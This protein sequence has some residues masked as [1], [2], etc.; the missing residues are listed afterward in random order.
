MQSN[1]FFKLKLQSKVS[2]IAILSSVWEMQRLDKDSYSEKKLTAY[3]KNSKKLLSKLQAKINQINK[4]HKEIYVWGAGVHTQK[5]LALTNLIKTRIRA[6]VDSNPNY[7]KAKLVDKPIITP[8]K[9][10]KETNLPILISSK[11]YQEDIKNQI[12]EMGLKNRILT[13]Y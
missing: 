13:L 9:L 2:V 1:G 11:G 12:K 8:N 7:H 6:F 5:L 3:I 4:N 10:F